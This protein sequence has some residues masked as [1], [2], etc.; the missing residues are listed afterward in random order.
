MLALVIVLGSCGGSTDAGGNT[1]DGAGAGLSDAESATITIADFSFGE[2]LSVP[3]GT[4]VSVV[5]A[6]G[7]GHTWTASDDTFDSGF[8]DPDAT[9]EFVFDEAG[10]FTFFCEIHSSMTGS[11]TVAP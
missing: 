8:L 4:S 11:I 3:V 6:D 2:S 9:F 5:N 1:D 10:T 7:V